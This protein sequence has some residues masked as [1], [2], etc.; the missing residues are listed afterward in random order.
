MNIADTIKIALQSLVTNKGRS[1]LTML[2]VIIGVASVI[3]LVSI[4]NGLRSQITQQ[5][6]DLGAN[7]IL[8]LPGDLFSEDGGGFPDE[9]QQVA[10]L[11]NNKLRMSHVEEARKVRQYVKAVAPQAISPVEASYQNKTKKTSVFAT[12]YEYGDIANSKPKEIGR[13]FT[14]T[15]DEKGD[16]VAVLGFK[17]NEELF[18]SVDPVGKN[19]K[20]NNQTFEVIGVVEEKGGSFGGPSFDTYI[21]IPIESYFRLFDTRQVLRMSVQ[22][23]S[24]ENIK[25]AIKA[26]DERLQRTLDDK[27]FSVFDQ[28]DILK[29]IDTILGA[30]TAGLG[31][32]AAI[33]LVVGGIG[34]MN[35][36]LV[37]VTER[38]REIG[39]RKAIGATPNIIMTQFLIESV[40]LSVLGGAIGVGIATLGSLAISSFIP[41][42]VSMDAISLAFGVSVAVGVVFGV[43]PARRAA[44]LSPIEALR[45]E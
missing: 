28:K 3:L 21:Y 14:K 27:D 33:S 6:E 25:A 11:S 7:T 42:K 38:T 8:V 15:E 23:D 39:L 40:T 17:I 26:V 24:P 19:I 20:I 18:G 16:R 36:M 31:G 43:Y 32:I 30:L 41:A 9:E 44:N 45:Y 1:L 10:A 29:V 22:V 12:S 37:S 34:I 5:F 35:I 13:F 2:G 4:G